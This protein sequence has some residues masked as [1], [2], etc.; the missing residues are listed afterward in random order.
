MNFKKLMLALSVSAAALSGAAQADRLEAVKAAGELSC[1]NSGAFPPFSFANEENKIVGFDVDICEE[2]AARLGVKANVISTAWDGIIAGLVS[3]KYDTIIGSIGVTEERA[4]AIDF[5]TTY[6]HSGLA[7]FVPNGS[8]L[9]SLDDL[10]GKTVGATLGELGE[11]WAQDRGGWTV[12]TY[13]SIPEMLLELKAGRID[14]VVADDIP[15]L[16]AVNEGAADVKALEIEGLPQFKIAVA[17]QKGNPELVA[18]I[19]QAITDMRADGTY[20]KI[21]EK[22]IGADI[23]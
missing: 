1:A 20:L 3:G 15:V 14:A 11:Q 17:T 13:K 16:V 2:I 23:W 8:E 9:A 22:W 5:T 6:Y 12:R 4:L 19:N 7:I 18:A 21:S 10:A